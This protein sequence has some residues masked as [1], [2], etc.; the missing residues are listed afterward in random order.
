[1]AP[2]MSPLTPVATVAKSRQGWSTSEAKEKP[3]TMDNTMMP[4]P[5]TGAD[6]QDD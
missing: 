1:M 4:M 5:R 2:A 3:A 6:L